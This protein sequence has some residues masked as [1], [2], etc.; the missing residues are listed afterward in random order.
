MLRDGFLDY[1]LLLVSAVSQDAIDILVCRAIAR[2]VVADVMGMSAE[3]RS[4]EMLRYGQGLNYEV[5]GP[6]MRSVGEVRMSEAEVS[7]I[8]GKMTREEQADLGSQLPPWGPFMPIG[9]WLRR[10]RAYAGITTFGRQGLRLSM[11][12]RA[13]SLSLPRWGAQVE[14]EFFNY[15]EIPCGLVAPVAVCILSMKVKSPNTGPCPEGFWEELRS[16]LP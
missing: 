7:G 10:W 6:G 3:S 8:E 14:F 2:R 9:I 5:D 15:N 11:L 1:V 16:R 12:D 4:W 13:L